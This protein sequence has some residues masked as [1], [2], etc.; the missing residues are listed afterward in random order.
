[1]ET[2]TQLSMEN[3]VSEIELVERARRGDKPSLDRLAGMARERLRVYVYRLT[4]KDDLTQEIVQESLLEMCKILGK[5]QKTDRFWPWLYGIATNKLHRHYRTEKAMRHAAAAEERRRGSMEQREQGLEDLVG[6]ELKQIVATAMQKLRTRHKAVLVMRCYDS[7]SYAEIAES[8]GCNEFSIRM[9]FVRAKRALQ[10]ELLRNGFGRGSL[11]AALIVFGK[12][13]APSKAAAAQLTVPATTLKVGLAATVAGLATSTAGVVSLAA[14][15][16]LTVGTIAVNSDSNQ[17]APAPA[18]ISI[19]MSRVISPYATS[20]TAHEQFWYYFPEGPTGPLMLRAQSKT[21]GARVLQNDQG[22]FS[23]QDGVVSRNNYRM[24]LD[25]LSV[26]KLPTD[27]P[28]LRGYLAQVEGIRNDIQPVLAGKGRGLLAVVERKTENGSAP[29]VEP[30]TIRSSNVLDSDYFQSDWPSGARVEDNRDAMHQRGWAFFRMRGEIRGQTVTG[31]GRIPFA[32][33]SSRTYSAWMHLKIGGAFAVVDSGVMTALQDGEGAVLGR[34]PRGSFFKGLSR[35]WMGL[36][37]LDAVRRD[38]A[39]QRMHFQTVLL[40]SRVA[41]VTIID[42]QTKLIYRI[43]VEADLVRQITMV[44]AGVP[45]GTLEFE[46]LQD[47]NVRQN[48]FAAPPGRNERTS[49]R[50]SSGLSWLVRLANG[51]LGG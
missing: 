42:Q 22:N 35:P 39:E 47:T 51:N 8:M 11:L 27:S 37:T 19:P 45:V 24:W 5:L 40:N 32:Y 1:M 41:E 3:Q 48:E 46:Y 18:V 12:M 36:H 10:K 7:M 16:A 13:T 14:A 31:V 15:G 38:A 9:L 17:P 21:S 23:F 2:T 20:H 26:L 33:A 34:Y 25:D 50:D 6:E 43:D 30:W 49:V 29:L 28:E 4:Q 44:V